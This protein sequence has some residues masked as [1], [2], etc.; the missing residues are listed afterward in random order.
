MLISNNAKQIELTIPTNTPQG[1][2]QAK[3]RKQNKSEYNSLVEDIRT[4]AWS[5]NY[6]TIEIGSLGHFTKATIK[7]VKSI[8]PSLLTDSRL[9]SSQ[10]NNLVR[11]ASR[12]SISCSQN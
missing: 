1:I 6:D 3:L 2:D 11:S 9:A 4:R 5:V 8:L 7:A 12:V 10:T